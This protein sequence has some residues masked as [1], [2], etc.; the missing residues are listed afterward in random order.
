MQI[1]YPPSKRST[2]VNLKANIISD[3]IFHDKMLPILRQMQL[4]G[5]SKHVN[6]IRP[7]Y[8]NVN[9]SHVD[10]ISIHIVDLQ[11]V[12]HS[13]SNTN[14]VNCVLHFRKKK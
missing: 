4:S 7:L 14:T 5:K 6:I 1:K 10:K 13:F 9:Q 2:L 12:T 3:A 11:G 8:V